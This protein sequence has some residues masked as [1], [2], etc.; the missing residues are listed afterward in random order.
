M[1]VDIGNIHSTMNQVCVC[2]HKPQAKGIR[3]RAFEKGIKRNIFT[4]LTLNET[5]IKSD[6]TRD[7]AYVYAKYN[8]KH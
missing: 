7:M 1:D 2:E 6:M 5:E 3:L 4:C 8:T